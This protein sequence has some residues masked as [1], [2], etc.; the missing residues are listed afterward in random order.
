MNGEETPTS[1]LGEEKQPCN[2]TFNYLIIKLWKNFTSACMA[3]IPRRGGSVP[4]TI[5][6]ILLFGFHVSDT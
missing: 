6:I 1:L 3:G 5:I 2:T 4:F